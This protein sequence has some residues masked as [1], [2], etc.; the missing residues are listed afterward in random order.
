MAH[1]PEETLTGELSEREL[2][3]ASDGRVVAEILRTG[4]RYTVVK[5]E[6]ATFPPSNR[7]RLVGIFESVSEARKAA[8]TLD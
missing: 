3:R 5:R 6:R 7:T 2:V 4:G 8:S 1:D